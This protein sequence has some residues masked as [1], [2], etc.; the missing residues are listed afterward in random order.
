MNIDLPDDL[1]E[2]VCQFMNEPA[3]SDWCVGNNAFLGT[4]P[5]DAWKLGYKAEVE[6]ALHGWADG[7]FA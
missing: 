1:L 5:V 4:R 7:S 2:L 6:G 3:A